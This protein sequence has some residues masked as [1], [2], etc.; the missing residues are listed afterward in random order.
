MRRDSRPGRRRWAVSGL[1]ATA[2]LASAAAGVAQADDADGPGG[3]PVPVAITGP[4]SYALSLQAEGPPPGESSFGIGLRGPGEAEPDE[5]GVVTPIHHGD[6]TV[7]IDASSLEGVA[8]VDLPCDADGLVATC[9]GHEI[10]AGAVHND[11]WGVGLRPVD[12]SA[13]GDTGSVVVTGRGEGLEFTRHTVDVFVGGPKFRMHR[14][15]EPDGFAAGDVFKPRMAF[16]NVGGVAAEGVALRF[17]GSRG[18][19][20]PQKFSNCTYATENDDN[21]IRMRHVAVCTFEGT[22]EPGAAYRVATPVKVKAAD[23][24]LRDVF[25]YRFAALDP[26]EAGALR[27]EGTYKKGGGKELTLKQVQG[28]GPYVEYAEVDLPT[29][30]T[31]D[32]DLV[33][34]RVSGAEGETVTAKVALH[35]RGPA[36]IGS[37]RSG[38]EPLGFTVDI[39]EGATVATAPDGCNKFNQDGE[40]TP[41]TYLCWADTPLLEDTVR[42]FSF[43]LRID[44]VVEGAK[45]VAALPKWEDPAEADPSN[46]DGW[47]VLNGTG[48]EETPGDTGGPGGPGDGSDQGD[49]PD[50]TSGEDSDAGSEDSTDGGASGGTDGTDGTDTDGGSLALTGTGAM[51]MGGLALALLTAGGGLLVLR[52]RRAAQV[53]P[54]ALA[55]DDP[56]A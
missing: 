32:L 30:N 55:T 28:G 6:W 12:A 41:R 36:W 18:L 34:D 51:S 21:L 15:A 40:T 31:Y 49:G 16:R 19:T 5:D 9:S 37:L 10:F 24:A 17:S 33:G 53:T 27:G 14:P 7:T 48:D 35:N 22:Y 20:F 25:A 13:A 11:D 23:F 4:D 1:T 45:G 50:D 47:I 3:A 52:R 26:S 56:A 2:L 29:S 46:D 42:E 54:V 8:D 44:E 43:A 38:G 39:P